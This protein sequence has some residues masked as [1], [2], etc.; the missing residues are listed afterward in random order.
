MEL[1]LKGKHVIVT[2]GGTNIGR[3]IVHGFG[4]EGSKIS[5]AELVPSQGEIVAAEVAAM[6]SGAVVNVIPTDVTDPEKVAAMQKA[7]LTWQRSVVQS[8]N[9]R[10]YK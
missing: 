7:L 3:A 10:D 2:G 1:G 5:I 6:D 8:L 4:A 9:G